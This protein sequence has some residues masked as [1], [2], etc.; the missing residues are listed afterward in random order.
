MAFFLIEV[1][2]GMKTDPETSLE[3]HVEQSL[4]L[5]ENVGN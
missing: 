5:I 4:S 3:Q 2:K 1:W